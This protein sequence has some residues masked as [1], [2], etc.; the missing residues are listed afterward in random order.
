LHHHKDSETN[1][2]YGVSAKDSALALMMDDDAF[3]FLIRN[4]SFG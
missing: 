3:A 1:I 4:P 2:C